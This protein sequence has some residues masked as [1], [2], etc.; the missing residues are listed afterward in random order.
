QIVGK[1]VIAEALERVMPAAE[2]QLELLPS[3]FEKGSPEHV[4]QLERVRRVG[5]PPGARNLAQRDAIEFIRKTIGDP[6]LLRARWLLHSPES[7]AREFGC[8]ALEAFNLLDRVAADLMRYCYAPRAAE[9]D[10]G[11]AVVPNFQVAIGGAVAG[12]AGPPPWQY[13]LD[14]ERAKKE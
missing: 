9:D 2:Q 3:K 4:E 8:S 6:M 10:K 13:L 11:N 7:L 12:D 1:Q 5:R 14:D